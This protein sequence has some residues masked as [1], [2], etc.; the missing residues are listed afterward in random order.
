[1]Q[2]VIQAIP[3]TKNIFTGQEVNRPVIRRVA[4]Y[5]RVSTDSEEQQSSYRNQVEYYE[6]E[7]AQRPDW[8]LYK[9]YTDEGISGTNT[10]RRDGFNQMI[11]DAL[12]GKFDLIVTKSVSRFARNTV[13]FLSTVRLLKEHGV[14]VYFETQ[15]LYTFDSNGEFMITLLCSLAQEDSNTLS[16]NTTWGKRQSFAKGNVYLPYKRFL[17]FKKGED[18]FPAIVESEAEIARMIYR[19][20]LRGR[21]DNWIANEL[22]RLDIPTKTGVKKWSASTV[23]GIATNEKY[24]GASL[25]QKTYTKDFLSKKRIKNTGEV[26]QYY[27]EHSHEAI[28]DPKEFDLVQEI[29][30]KRK[31]INNGFIASKLFC[32]DCGQMYGAKVWH[33]N[34]KY[35]KVIYRCNSKYTNEEKCQTPAIGEDVLKA[36][37]IKAVNELLL[38]RS[39]VIAGCKL[40]VDVMGTDELYDQKIFELWAEM[41]AISKEMRKMIEDNARTAMPQD[42]FTRAFQAKAAEYD[43]LQKQSKELEEQKKSRSLRQKKV[44]LFIC[45][46]DKCG[47]L[48]T[49][50][51]DDLWALLLDKAVVYKDWRIVFEFVNGKK[52]ECRV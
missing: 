8:Q 24:K 39:E 43:L 16:K 52:V 46:L 38:C 41:D 44:E 25:L 33:S 12:A 10:K 37:F 13:D 22:T 29:R 30:A 48:L 31:G 28:I 51:D 9:I 35:R 17:G 50:F 47:D 11:K 7:V 6:K 23:G 19:Y 3:I 5:A 45:Q 18:G 20:Q 26:Q 36:G 32:G 27:I 2:R 4:P 40:A 49:E 1:M 15:N 42:E 21:T 14:E 34:D